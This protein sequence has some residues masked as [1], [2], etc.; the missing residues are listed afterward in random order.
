LRFATGLIVVCGYLALSAT[1]GYGVSVLLIPFSALLLSRPCAR[2]D[3]RY[4]GYARLTATITVCCLPVLIVVFSRAGLIEAVTWLFILVQVY[5]LLHRKT[6]LSYY[7]LMLTALFLIV[8]A[9][10]G[11][12]DATVGIV[13]FLSLGGAI[14]ALMTLQLQRDLDAD[15]RSAAVEIVSLRSSR[16]PLAHPSA[17][18]KLTRPT[19]TI[20]STAVLITGML[21]MLT[22]RIDFSP[23]RIEAPVR[24][25]RTGLTPKN[26]PASHSGAPGT[27]IRVEDVTVMRVE[28]PEAPDG[29]YAGP[30]YWRSHTR[31]LHTSLGWRYV[32][33]SGTV[34]DATAA[35][36]FMT[37]VGEDGN[38]GPG[39]VRSRLRKGRVVHHVC[40]TCARHPAPA[41][42]LVQKMML[43]DA[44]EHEALYWESGSDLCVGL[45]AGLPGNLDAVLAEYVGDI[46]TGFVALS[47]ILDEV[48]GTSISRT[49][50]YDV[51]SEVEEPSAEQRR[52][53]RAD[54]GE[55]FSSKDY[56]LLTTC[57]LSPKTV[58]LA[59]KLTRNQANVH[60]KVAAIQAF[61]TSP[62]FSYS[63]EPI[64]VP[65]RTPIESFIHITKTGHC[66]LFASAM[67]LMVRSLGIPARVVS[68]YKGGEWSEEERCYVV[69]SDMAHRWVEVYFI[70]YGWVTFDPTP[71]AGAE[72]P[73][74]WPLASAAATWRFKAQMLWY[75]NVVGFD[76]SVH[77]AE[78]RDLGLRLLGLAQ[79]RPGGYWAARRGAAR[80]AVIVLTAVSLT[81]GALTYARRRRRRTEN[82]ALSADQVRAVRL[83]RV[84]TRR[85][86]RFGA[87]CAGKTAEEIQAD[88]CQEIFATPERT[89]EA[90][91]VY[92]AAR[93]GGRSLDARQFARLRRIVSNLQPA[94]R[95]PDRAPK[96]LQIDAPPG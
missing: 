25:L 6:L 20:F 22:P 87:P 51:W 64:P 19:I 88:L 49:R 61:L 39:V 9:C 94:Q 76:A 56:H 73:E 53:A 5:T 77:L 3:A 57:E 36:T 34:R 30:M 78:L 65:G 33:L 67:A 59:R 82:R 62:N 80:T 96:R 41:L 75:R 81:A 29:R 12:P 50:R 35:V 7:H 66:E 79:G 31:N 95:Q 11:A 24:Q 15:T 45:S 69:R 37:G 89:R 27:G 14:L 26:A 55:V 8:V 70:D 46:S 42:P 2:L 47:P 1:D 16:R 43:R 71:D 40:E 48:V 10:M 84:L 38:P 58:R 4:K 54:Y 17:D 21:F 44:D 32:E 92:N 63:L 52:R 74:S 85:L 91:A 68:G 93:F 28:F 86:R 60:D 18:V 90:L 23:G 13:L 72:P 83:H